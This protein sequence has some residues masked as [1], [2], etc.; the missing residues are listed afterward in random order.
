MLLP[1]MD[2]VLSLDQWFSCFG[3]VL[4]PLLSDLGLPPRHGVEQS[5]V[6]ETRMRV[7]NILTKVGTMLLVLGIILR[8]DFSSLL[9]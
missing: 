1:D 3:Q 2:E 5:I 4:F 8:L 9:S 7:C 6:D